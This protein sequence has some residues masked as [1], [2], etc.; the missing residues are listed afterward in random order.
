MSG[1]KVVEYPSKRSFL[2]APHG[3]PIARKFRIG[4]LTPVNA[5]IR[6]WKGPGRFLLESTRQGGPLGRYSFAGG[7]PR[8]VFQTKGEG[9]AIQES[10]ALLSGDGY[11]SRDRSP[12][13][14][15]R[16]LLNE[17][18]VPQDPSLPPFQGGAVGYFSYE[19]VRQW[20][21]LPERALDDLNLPEAVLLFVELLIAFDH[22]EGDLWLIFNPGGARFRREERTAL[23]DEGMERIDSLSRRI[24]SPVEPDEEPFTPALFRPFMAR[25]EY[26]ERVRRCQEYIAAGDI[27]QANLSHR[28]SAP[29]GITSPLT[30]YRRLS[31]VNPSPFSAYLDLGDFSLV[32]SSPERL[33]KRTG[34]HVETRPIA[35]TRPRGVLP[36]EDR[37]LAEEL[38]SN[39]KERAEH[40]MLVDLERNDLGKISRFGSVKVDEWMGIERYSH[41]LHI[42]SNVSGELLPGKDAVDQLQAVFPGGTITGVPKIRCMEII[43]ELE[44]VV[45]GPYTGAIGYLGA[46][47]DLDLSI[48]IRTLV[49]KKETLY[50]QVGAGIVADSDPEREYEETLH[51]AAAAKFSLAARHHR[52]E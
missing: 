51:K 9:I 52:P 39:E 43:N 21:R 34:N 30:L 20:E 16:R 33:I 46:G 31:V 14:T 17:A 29:I 10:P 36:D 15:L 44:P 22:A 47:G 6:A 48:A 13:F 35:G 49:I 8:F 23:W 2:S 4:E 27:F 41:V 42:V 26:I 19:L 37:R 5:L 18:F 24:F 38:L 32:G 40:I 28:F 12:L 1:D 3:R 50:L 25:E 45:R 7:S 11:T